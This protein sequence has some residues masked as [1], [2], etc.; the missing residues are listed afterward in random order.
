MLEFSTVALLPPLKWQVDETFI[1]LLKYRVGNH[2]QI[3][4]ILSS[5]KKNVGKKTLI[6]EQLKEYLFFQ[7]DIMDPE[8]LTLREKIILMDLTR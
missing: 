3:N 7:D 8:N 2:P 1:N 5:E 4:G 6:P